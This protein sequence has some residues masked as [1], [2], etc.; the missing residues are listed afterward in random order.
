M[1]TGHWRDKFEPRGPSRPLD[2]PPDTDGRDDLDDAPLALDLA[3][4]RP[5]TIQ[6]G[7]T[8]PAALLDLRRYDAR[9]GFW[10]G[11]AIAY[12]HLVAAEYVGERMLSLDFG[13][14]H[15]MIEGNGLV[16]LVGLLQQG[17][18]LALQEYAADIWPQRPSGAI[19]TAIK[20]LGQE[21]SR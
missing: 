18:V 6:R 5:W 1:S 19:I 9:S 16:A 14:R 8:R 13:T 7:R 2:M 12:P 21:Q 20:R 4:Y 3:A 17:T 10:Q 15:F 11:W